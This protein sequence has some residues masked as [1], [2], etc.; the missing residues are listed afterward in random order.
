MYSRPIIDKIDPLNVF[1]DSNSFDSFPDDD[2]KLSQKILLFV[3]NKKLRFY[4]T[5]KESSNPLILPVPEI[6]IWLSEEIRWLSN[7]FE[8]D[9]NITKERYFPTR[10]INNFSE[11]IFNDY[12]HTPENIA[13]ILPILIHKFFESNENASI[14]I[15]DNEKLLSYRYRLLNKENN[16]SICIFSLYDANLFLDL[17]FKR[18]N[19]YFSQD[20]RILS[21]GYWYHLSAYQK[22]PHIFGFNDPIMIGLFDR[23]SFALKCLDEIGIQNFKE[24]TPDNNYIAMYHFTYLISLIT[25]I[26]DNLAILTDTLLELE[27]KPPEEITLSKNRK[28]FR[29]RVNI[30]Y[31]ELFEY[32][33]NFDLFIALIHEFREIAV[34]KEGFHSLTFRNTDK[35]TGF[36]TCFV[37]L[38][39]KMNKAIDLIKKNEKKPHVR[40]PKSDWGLYE[41]DKEFFIN[42]YNFS[43][44]AMSNLVNF[45]DGYLELIRKKSEFKNREVKREDP[46]LDLFKKFHLGF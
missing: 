28:Y 5:E 44:M 11:E 24:I 6:H 7:Q 46:D 10:I 18:N 39:E 21:V 30:T 22:M 32:I 26:F 27:I 35:K 8:V 40:Y 29:E 16:F 37:K 23:M 2:N 20:S 34:H 15:T 42:P 14:Y 12:E 31:L 41:I 38:P 45:T 19:L 4:R 13:I 3:K 25:G 36:M 17:F 1:I 43:L 33:Q 9:E